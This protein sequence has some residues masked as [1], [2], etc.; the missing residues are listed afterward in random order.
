MYSVSTIII[1]LINYYLW[2]DD[3]LAKLIVSVLLIFNISKLNAL[4]LIGSL[5]MSELSTELSLSESYKNK[6]YFIYIIK[7]KFI[8]Y[9]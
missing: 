4:F 2:L 5:S 3:S 7:Q 9:T 8:W 1:K 6:K